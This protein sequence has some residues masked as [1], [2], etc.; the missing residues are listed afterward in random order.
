MHPSIEIQDEFH[1]TGPLSKLEGGRGTVWRAG[2]VTLKPL[3]V[4]PEE[5]LWMDVVARTQST[6]S[7]MR[8]SLPIR[9]RSEKLVVDGWTAFPYL[10]GEHQPGRWFELAKIARE[11]AKL[12]SEVERPAFVDIRTHAWARADRFAWGEDTDVLLSD[13]PHVAELVGARQQ[14]FDPSGVIHGDLTGN[15]LFTSALPPAVLDLTIY[16]RPV[17]YSVAII[18]VDAV[19]FE[20]APLA[21]L[22]TISPAK[23]FPQYL[24][25]ALLFR[26]VT[27]YLNGRRASEYGVYDSVVG[28]TLELAASQ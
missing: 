10:T 4:I 2:D 22:E 27:D 18:A 17:N 6:N 11:F 5:L 3:D 19:C 20:G 23:D 16:W 13:V 1:A 24:V 15:V 21:L 7:R 8:L 9:S 12:F 25:R 26:I 28:C 14:V